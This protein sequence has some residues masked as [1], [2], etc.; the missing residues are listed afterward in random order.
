MTLEVRCEGLLQ[1]KF[2]QPMIPHLEQCIRMRGQ[3]A[4]HQFERQVLWLPDSSVAPKSCFHGWTTSTSDSRTGSMRT[5]VR[6][7]EFHVC[8]SSLDR[9]RVPAG[10]VRLEPERLQHAGTPGIRC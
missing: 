3:Y 8:A 9:R 10:I 7:D 6:S 1:E 4:P 5:Y 2:A